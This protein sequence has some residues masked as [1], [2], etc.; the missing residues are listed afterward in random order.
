M[1]KLLEHHPKTLS[2]RLVEAVKGFDLFNARGIHALP[3]SVTAA[4]SGSAL[5]ARV[6]ALQLGHHLLHRAAGHKLDHHKGHQQ[7]PEQGRD[8]QKQAFENVG[9][10]GSG[11]LG[12]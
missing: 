2:G 5:P 9:Q 6:T 1:R 7:D 12:G 8:H 4:C 11:G 3:A 10:H